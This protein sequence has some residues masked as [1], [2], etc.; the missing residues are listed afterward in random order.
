MQYLLKKGDTTTRTQ[1][2]TGHSGCELNHTFDTESTGALDPIYL[3]SNNNGVVFQT[4]VVGGYEGDPAVQEQLTETYVMPEEAVSTQ[5]YNEVDFGGTIVG[6]TVISTLGIGA[7]TYYVSYSNGAKPLAQ[8]DD[9]AIPFDGSYGFSP[10]STVTEVLA[11]FTANDPGATWTIENGDI[12]I[13]SKNP[14]G[15]GSCLQLFTPTGTG[16]FESITGFVEYKEPVDGAT[17]G[18][19]VAG[20]IEVFYNSAEA[21]L[22]TL[23][24]T[25]TLGDVYDK[26]ALSAPEGYSATND[27]SIVILKTVAGANVIPLSIDLGSTGI[28]KDTSVLIPGE[29]ADNDNV[30]KATSVATEYT[31]DTIS[32][33]RNGLALWNEIDTIASG[34]TKQAVISHPVTAVR[35]NVKTA[36]RDATAQVILRTSS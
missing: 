13:T 3:S 7:S 35:L 20:D 15:P 18:G 34:N 30:P 10:A 1:R 12:R 36:A 21:T 32:N 2:I 9:M 25:E 29:D 8:G 17:T 26:I 4:K 22:V 14:A 5:G 27:G 28:T 31:L 19:L 33:V 16:F 11:F 6:S 23:D 24:G